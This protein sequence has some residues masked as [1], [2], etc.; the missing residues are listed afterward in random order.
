MASSPSVTNRRMTAKNRHF[1]DWRIH[2]VQLR[3]GNVRLNLGYEGMPQDRVSEK[4]AMLLCAIRANHVTDVELALVAALEKA[5]ENETEKQYT[6]D[7]LK[8]ALN[9]TV[10]ME[11]KK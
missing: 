11:D 9:G 4:I 3:S 5:L 6:A 1:H 2:T 10:T 8:D 7:F